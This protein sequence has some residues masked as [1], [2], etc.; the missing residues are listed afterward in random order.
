[1]VKPVKI[2]MKIKNF[3]ALFA[4]FSVVFSNSFAATVNISS[5]TTTSSSSLATG[6]VVNFAGTGTLNVDATKTI[7]SVTTN[8]T[9]EGVI[10]FS[11]T[12]TL[13]ASGDIGSSSKKISAITFASDGN[14]TLGGNL[15]ANLGVT[16]TTDKS[17]NI[18]LDGSSLQTIQSTIG[19]S[20]LRIGDLLVN[21]TAGANFNGAVYAD[22]FSTVSSTDTLEIGGAGNLDFNSS[23]IQSNLS[24]NR[25]GTTSLGATSLGDGKALAVN[26]DAQ[27]SSLSSTGTGASISLASGKTLTVTGNIDSKVTVDGASAGVGN[28][29]FGGT[30]AQSVDS[31]IGSSK[32][33]GSVSVG[34][35]NA[36]GVTFNNSANVGSL[37]FS[38]SSGTSTLNIAS[39]KTLDVTKNINVTSG[40]TGVIAGSGTLSLSGSSAQ[41]VAAKLGTSTS[42]R[43]GVLTISNNAGVTLNGD[44][45]V[46]KLNANA[47]TTSITANGI[48]NVSIFAA[49][50]NTTVAGSGNI[51][52][53]VTTLAAAKTIT[54]NS[55]ATI[56]SLTSGDS[57]S[58][59]SIASGKTL[60]LSGDVSGSGIAKG[61]GNIAFAGA[62]A[63]AVDSNY[64]IGDSSNRLGTLSFSNALGVTFNNDAYA[65]AVDFTQSSGSAN[66]KIASG[67]TLD[68]TGDVNNSSGLTSYIDGAG[69][70]KLSGSSTQRINA[71]LGSSTSNRL[72]TLEVNNAAGVVF[73]ADNY[74]GALTLTDGAITVS[75]NST[76]DVSSALDLSSQTINYA[77]TDAPMPFGD[78]K[79]SA[80]VT[81]GSG[82]KI[83]FDYT[84]NNTSIATGTNYT[85]IES[86]TGITGSLSNVTVTDNSYLFNN[87]LALS[88]NKIVTSVSD[89]LNF[90]AA[91][92]GQNNYDLLNNAKSTDLQPGLF[93]IASQK[94]LNDTIDS[95]K[96]MNNSAQTSSVI[97]GND[98]LIRIV[99]NIDDRDPIQ[100]KRNKNLWGKAFGSILDQGSREGTYGYNEKSSGLVFGY[101][102]MISKN[103]VIGAAISFGRSNLTG[104][105]TYKNYVGVNN[106]QLALY[107]KNGG[108]NGKMGFYNNNA[109]VLGFNNYDTSRKIIAGSINKTATGKFS[110]NSQALKIGFGYKAKI[111]ERFFIDP[112]ASLEYFR[113]ASDDYQEKG[114]GNI[115]LQVSNQNLSGAMSDIG[116]SLGYRKQLEHYEVIPK[117]SLN[118]LHTLSDY[119]QN[120]T[121]NF[122]GQ[123]S[124]IN[125]S[126]IALQNNLFNIGAG[127][128]INDG[129]DAYLQLQYD[130][131]LGKN[132]VGNMLSAR[133]VY[134]F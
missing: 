49:N 125:N 55:S 129:D 88:G 5:G 95:L 77:V 6:D 97:M 45:Y 96:P 76:T 63:Q 82:T 91:S 19:S 57:S 31:Q 110:G 80:G 23:S 51:S 66:L 107:N 92:L 79:S 67:K 11:S 47:A 114:A 16:T 10:N 20:A 84:N 98:N 59:L 111:S 130:L 81:I 34:N 121:I 54:F 52:L 22:V 89:S 44:A 109:L 127:F 46:S 32:R 101:D 30:V 68:V 61:A 3:I 2:L 38:Q 86:A 90:S 122:I 9:D 70:V 53:G 25:A 85:I 8:T 132:L 119:R 24:I 37:S 117:L 105:S 15:Y 75:G 99:N 28:L 39:G 131:K 58:T 128:V 60:T 64:K 65:S 40:A 14:L 33:V 42:N 123:N 120:S 108:N 71:G 41:T 17:G 106:Y 133:Y 124:K 74:L 83:N 7:N 48:L 112:N 126:A 26:S 21:Q 36:S 29:A 100:K 103:S 116:L 113:V 73:N 4:I 94:E 69:K 78:L 43:L 50:E 102:E 87:S 134:V 18:T 104:D 56:S 1:M 115:G 35:T 93:A 72:S 12:N 62:S 13:T 27:V 118:W